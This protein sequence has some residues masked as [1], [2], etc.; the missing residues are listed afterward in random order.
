QLEQQAAAARPPPDLNHY[1]VAGS[2][3]A[4]IATEARSRQPLYDWAGLQQGLAATIGRDDAQTRESFQA[5]EK[6]GT[7]GFAKNDVDL[8]NFFVAT[9]KTLLSPGPVQSGQLSLKGP[10]SPELFASFSRS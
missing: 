9:S 6:A 5:I 3:F 1:N 4:R 8:A 7:K 10:N 2:A